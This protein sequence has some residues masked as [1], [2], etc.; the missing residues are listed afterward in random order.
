MSTS[1]RSFV[2]AGLIATAFAALPLKTIVGQSWKQRDGNPGETPP[3]QVDPLANYSKATFITYL[4]SIFQLHTVTG[5]VEVTLVSVDDMPAPKGGEC[6]MLT[7][8]GGSGP[9]RQDTYTLVH[10]SLGTFQLFLVPG[11]AD[12]N[13]AQSYL[14]TIN[15]LSLVDAAKYPPP[16]AGTRPQPTPSKATPPPS[17]AQAPAQTPAPNTSPSITPPAQSITPPAPPANKPNRT[18]KPS[19]KFDDIED[20]LIDIN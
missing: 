19:W 3:A 15:R 9:Q 18:R 14:A 16:K 13:G 1:R 10:S 6:F 12:Q 7:F 2:K 4:N 11:A 5:I 20:P 8:R 17:S